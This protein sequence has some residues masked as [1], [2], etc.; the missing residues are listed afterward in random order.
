MSLMAQWLAVAFAPGW[1]ERAI[2][3]IAVVLLI[4]LALLVAF[5]LAEQASVRGRA[6]AVSRS[7]AR[8][9]NEATTVQACRDGTL[10]ARTTTEQT[11]LCLLKTVIGE[12]R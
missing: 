4:V 1:P 7:W 11:A 8:A 12:H 6:R 10:I 5:T 9:A 2:H 3:R